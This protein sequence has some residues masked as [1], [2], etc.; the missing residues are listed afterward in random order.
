MFTVLDSMDNVVPAALLTV[1]TSQCL[2]V[3]IA[4]LSMTIA[5]GHSLPLAIVSV[6]IA[7][8]HD[9]ARKKTQRLL[10]LAMIL[11]R[12]DGLIGFVMIGAEYLWIH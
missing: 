7:A 2:V 6:T 11:Y 1:A 10:W 4:R 3:C 9:R 8:Q 5:L 12:Q